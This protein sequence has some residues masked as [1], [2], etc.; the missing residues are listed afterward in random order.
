MIK[1]CALVVT[2]NRPKLLVR[3]LDAL[4]NQSLK[5]DAIIIIDNGS[6]IE[7][8]IKLKETNYI[9]KNV[10]DYNDKYESEIDSIRNN[11]NIHYLSF[12][13]NKGPGFAFYRGVQ[14][15]ESLNY[16]WLWMMDDD[17]FPDKGC[18][19]NLD[20]HSKK[21]DFLNPVVLD[22][23]KTDKLAFGLYDKKKLVEIKTKDDAIKSAENG[24]IHGVA[25][26]F[27]GTYVSRRLVN[28]IGFPQHEMYGW[29]V[30]VEYE[31]RAKKSG[32]NVVTVAEAYHFHPE[33][34]VRQVSILNGKYRLNL[35][36][37]SFKNY[38]DIRNRNYIWYRYYGLSMNIKYF[39]AY[40]YYF[41]S[42]NKFR[43]IVLYIE[44]AIDGV[45]AK[46]NKEKRFDG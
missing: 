44:A 25:N 42:K 43:S 31:N 7:T 46:W 3:C 36:T 6:G 28:E 8:K 41:V 17:G 1:R 14:L 12:K 16:N 9:D 33:S 29:G 15:F 18:L 20:I 39:M 22:E 26:P 13:Y 32:F 5:L 2:Y 35:Q 24:L 21:A 11:I 30:E 19:F 37:N 4:V 34:R 40:F 27:N 10:N 45:C 38:I 23:K